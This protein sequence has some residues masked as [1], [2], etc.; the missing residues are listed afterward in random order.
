MKNLRLLFIFLSVTLNVF[1]QNITSSVDKQKILIGEQ[2]QWQLQGNFAKGKQIHWPT[3]D[4]IPHFEVL[5]KSAIDSQQTEKGVTMSQTFTVTSWDSGQWTLPSFAAVKSKTNLIKIDVSFSSFDPNQPYHDIKDI[6]D[7]KKPV[8]SNWWWYLVGLALLLA[9]FLLFFP[10]SKKK[11]EEPVFVPNEGAYKTALKRLEKLK[12]QESQD[13]KLFY[14]ELI[15]IFREYLLKRKNIQSYSKTTDDLSNQI[16]QLN[17]QK[18]QYYSLV[19]TLRL[20]DMVKFARFQPTSE[21]NKTSVE[22]I[23]ESIVAIENLN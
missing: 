12:A 17:M 18:D 8:Q 1:A 13:A 10:G 5:K 22:T 9:L 14:T 20:S 21:E 23:K 16:T 15:N 19:Q 4:S 7:V 3:V 6:L 11:K 2:F